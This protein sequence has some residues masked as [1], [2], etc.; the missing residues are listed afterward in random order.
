MTDSL[1]MTFDPMTIEH[2][3]VRMYSTLPPVLGELVANSYDADASYVQIHLMDTDNKEIT[4]EDDGAGM[5]FDEINTKFLRIGRNRRENDGTQVTPGGRK[6]IGKKGLGKLSFFG[7]AHEIMV[8]TRKD[9]K[10]TTFVLDWDRIKSTSN[11]ENG[12]GDYNPQITENNVDCDEAD[13]TTIHLKRIQRSSNFDAE[14]MANSLARMFICDATFQI[15]VLRNEDKAVLVTEERRYANLDMQIE[16]QIP[17][18]VSFESAYDKKDEISGVV[19]TTEKPISPRTNTRGITLFSRKKL[20]NAPEYFSDSA[21]S[22]FFS[23]LTGWL[24]V[25]FIDDLPEDV[26]GTNRQTLNW[27]HPD[28]VPLRKH[29]QLLVH[30]ISLDWREQRKLKRREKIG[31]KANIN[32]P[33][34]L[35]T[36]PKDIESAMIRIVE[37]VVDDSELEADKQDDV[38]AALHTIVPEYPR[39]HWRHLHSEIR[40]ASRDDY[41]SEDYYRAFQ[42]AAK[43]FIT[44][45]RRKSGSSNPTDSGMM[46][47]VFGRGKPMSVTQSYTKPDGSTFPEDTLASI[48]DGQ[49]FLSMGMVAGGRNPVSHEEIVDLRDSGLFTEKDCLDGLSLLSHLTRRLDDA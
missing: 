17:S 49:K 5:S 6:V 31:V 20:V 12:L 47:E 33:A 2:L 8:T 3:G 24:Q 38:V 7:I 26:I 9:R 37:S 43:R 28:M 18:G 39:Y 30:A 23:Y 41:I 19:F 11:P 13:G 4:V 22:H 45:V 44:L 34:W 36:L 1:K 25:D 27:N 10:K 35:G 46:G 48:E 14:A 15:T 16:W 42:E 40:D 29:L 21:S 32:V